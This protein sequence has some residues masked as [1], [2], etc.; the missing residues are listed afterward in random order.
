MDFKRIKELYYITPID[1]VPSI[2]KHGIFSHHQ[3][4]KLPHVDISMDEVQ[5]RRSKKRVPGGK[6][7]HKYANLY[8]D[9][10]NPMLSKR[11][12]MNS[13][14]CILCIDKEV[15]TLSNVVIT[16]RNA[17]SDYVRFL[18]F[19][20]GLKYLDEEK[21]YA[22]YWTH[23]DRFEYMERKSIKCAE[24]LI[25]DKVSTEYVFAANVYNENAKDKLQQHGFNLPLNIK[26]K[27]FF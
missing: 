15:L 20:D 21:V 16:D 3:A 14:I 25:P 4:K 24:V 2:L 17:S 5:E 19:P 6:H 9:A 22:Q 11:R 18:P 12:S 13:E 8:F 23:N 7:L 1:T 27:I 26:P 10:H